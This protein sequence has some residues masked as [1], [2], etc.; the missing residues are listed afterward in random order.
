MTSRRTGN[1]RRRA[2][3]PALAA[4]PGRSDMAQRRVPTASR[5]SFSNRAG[6]EVP[7]LYS[8]QNASSAASKSASRP[9]LT[10]LFLATIVGP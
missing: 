6:D 9:F 5:Y 1:N 7:R 4:G 8:S 2:P 3:E 10:A